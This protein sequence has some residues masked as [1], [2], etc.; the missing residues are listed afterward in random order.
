M[1]VDAVES[2]ASPQDV[3]Y[4]VSRVIGST[5]D[6]EQGLEAA[7]RLLAEAF[8][9]QEARIVLWDSK[10]GKPKLAAEI[11]SKPGEGM[12]EPCLPL[13]SNPLLEQAI[14]SQ[15]PLNIGDVRH[16]PLVRDMRDR[17]QECGVESLLFIPLL[18]GG[19]TLGV[20]E[21]YAV[22]EPRAFG[23]EEIT[24][25][26]AAAS[27][28][29]MAVENSD[30]ARRLEQA[31]QARTEFIDM[32]A[33]ELKQPMTALQGYT[34]MLT[35]GIA[36]ELNDRQKQFIEVIATSA[37]RMGKLV[38]DLLEISRLE[39]GRTRLQSAP[40]DLKDVIEETVAAARGKIEARQHLLEVDVG[41]DLPPVLGDRQRLVQILTNLVS[42]AYRYTPNGG[43]I[44]IA[45]GEADQAGIPSGY[46][47]VSVSDTG[48]GMSRGEVAK[49]GEKFFRGTHDLVRHQPGSGLGMCITRHLVLLHGSTLRIES[50][51][52][53]GSTFSFTVP[54]AEG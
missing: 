4:R 13:S 44:R 16:D 51:P 24:L 2:S 6:L 45:A 46:L 43:T 10:A 11:S 37:D 27:Y 47:C 1:S 5:M 35:M 50:E 54:V 8:G 36:G 42:N 18:R 12:G 34:K 30:L 20:L 9:I 15:Q 3:L 32:V 33:H 26:Q 25:A 29:A 7:I 48:I 41:R 28:L 17:L 52:D 31:D 21:I 40:I 14:S 22:Q 23:L 19:A 49:L 38:N 39:A 53:Q